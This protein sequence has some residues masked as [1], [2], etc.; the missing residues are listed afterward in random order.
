MPLFLC[1]G[2]TVKR[3]RVFPA[4]LAEKCL[5]NV[6]SAQNCLRHDRRQGE[7]FFQALIV[8]LLKSGA[9]MNFCDSARHAAACAPN[10]RQQCR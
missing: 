6:I 9:K 8:P 1:R 10:E 4:L 3:D 7:G 5:L 2:A